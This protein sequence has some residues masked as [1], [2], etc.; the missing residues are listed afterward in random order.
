MQ[1]PSVT[2]VLGA[3]GACPTITR[4]DKT[5]T[6]GHHTQR[7]KSELELLV[8]AY[9]KENVERLKE[10][11]D[12]LYAQ[13]SAGLSRL[14]RAGAFRTWGD[15]WQEA[16]SGPD[17]VPLM[18]ASLVRT[19]HQDF[20]LALAREIWLEQ[21][22]HVVDVLSVLL[23]DFFLAILSA[24]PGGDATRAATLAAMVAEERG[25]LARAKSLLATT[26]SAPSASSTA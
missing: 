4:G 10:L 13:E 17:R 19:K 5:W 3:S 23:P 6:V 2:Q 24:L 9:A 18:L 7:S 22:E 12:A 16:W 11:D 26:T 20:G 15:L 1:E 25:S 14:I 8:I 21:T